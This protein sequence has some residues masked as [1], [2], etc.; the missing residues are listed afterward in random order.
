[1]LGLANLMN[2]P[3]LDME[4]KLKI[5]EQVMI[6][7]G[8][9]DDLLKDLNIILYSQSALNK[10]KEKINI[11]Q[12]INSILDILN[13]QIIEAKAEIITQISDDS[14][15]VY[16]IKAYM[17]SILY[18]LIN[19]AIKFKSSQRPL[20]LKITSERTMDQLFIMVADN[21]IGIDLVAHGKNIFGLYKRFHLASEGKG[22]GL[23]MTK[24]QVEALGGKIKVE[25]EI[26]LGTTFTITLPIG[27]D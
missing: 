20:Q 1:M 10:N 27:L 15:E 22:L 25:S 23:H 6:S 17:E 5:M 3:K 2:M 24:I 16:T 21:G 4:E 19:N 26:G 9:M 8:K 7:V 18:N 11:E 14:Q 12:V 13:Q